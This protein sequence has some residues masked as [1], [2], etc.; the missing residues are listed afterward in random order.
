[1][2]VVEQDPTGTFLFN[3]TAE[4]IAI[5]P[6]PE[7][8]R[9]YR[10]VIRTWLLITGGIV[11]ASI[12]MGG[13]YL[14]FSCVGLPAFVFG[15]AAVV[16]NR[17]AGTFRRIPLIVEATGRVRY[18]EQVFSAPKTVRRLL[19]WGQR[20]EAGVVYVIGLEVPA[21]DEPGSLL[22]NVYLPEPYFDRIEK[23]AAAEWLAAQLGQR[24]GVTV[25]FIE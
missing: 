5:W 2:V 4:E 14:V 19:V 18:G 9:S 7:A 22:N 15:V 11:V 1:M 6:S 21:T 8:E 13:P 24:L 10:H 3:E 20:D 12:V 23:R 25:T 16:V 17:K